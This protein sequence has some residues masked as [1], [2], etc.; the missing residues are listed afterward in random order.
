MSTP[1]RF[2]NGVSNI[3]A[4]ET[5]SNFPAPDP[6]LVVGYFNDFYTY[7][8]TDWVL[9]TAESGSGSASEALADD[10]IGGV[11]LVTNDDANG[12]HDNF[13]LSKDGGTNDSEIFRLIAGKKAWF[14]ARF[15]SN[16][17]D[18]VNVILGIHIV[19][20]DPV[21]AAPTDG[22]YF[23]TTGGA[24]SLRCVKNSTASTSSIYALASD[25]TFYTVG[26]YFDGVNTIN[27]W[28]MDSAN[29]ALA[30]GTMT[31]GTAL[32]NDEYMPLSFGVEN[33]ESAANTLEL[34]YIGFWMER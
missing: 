34:D 5:M 19:N 31:P 8:A 24:L 11:L 9:T 2:N 20:T 16:D 12:D 14:K 30:V 26:Y 18:K 17:I 4:G 29:N 10:E 27:Y 22:C 25:D 1:K 7:A 28:L 15:K 23:Q 21:N 3:P 6:T 32:P 33:E 13:Q